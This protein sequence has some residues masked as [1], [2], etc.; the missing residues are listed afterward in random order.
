MLKMR[1]SIDQNHEMRINICPQDLGHEDA[2][3]ALY[4]VKIGG[5]RTQL[6]QNLSSVLACSGS[7][8]PIVS[9]DDSKERN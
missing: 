8:E 4:I 2:S 1:A 6:E 9:G 3:E 7:K 5:T